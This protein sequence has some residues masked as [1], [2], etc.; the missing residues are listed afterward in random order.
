V[1]NT[2]KFGASAMA[3]AFALP[4]AAM[5]TAYDCGTPANAANPNV[6]NCVSDPNH[7]QNGITYNQSDF[8]PAA[9][10]K[11][12]LNGTVVDTPITNLVGVSV[13]GSTNNLAEIQ[14][15]SG[16]VVTAGLTGLQTTSS[17]TGASVIDNAGSIT[18]VLYGLNAVASTSGGT[19]TATVTNDAASGVIPAGSV[20]LNAPAGSSTAVAIAAAG[21][22]ASI[23]NSGT[24]T[25]NVS[26]SDTGSVYAL[27]ASSYAAGGTVSVTNNAAFSIT[28]AQASL[29]GLGT[30][31]ST[32]A[33]N[34]TNNAA[35]SL[36]T[37]SG[38]SA[39]GF[40]VAQSGS[41]AADTLTNN[42]ALTVNVAGSGNAYGID[43][44]QGAGAVALNNNAAI[45]AT[46]ASGTAAAIRVAGA[47][48]GAGVTVNNFGSLSAS[49][50]SAYGVDVEA[51]TSFTYGAPVN[52]ASGTITVTGTGSGGTIAGIKA[53]G[54][55]GGPVSITN[56]GSLLKVIATGSETAY[57]LNVSG[58]TTQTVN[59]SD[60]KLGSTV[61]AGDITVS[62]GGAATGIA[63]A[64][65]TGAVNLGLTGASLS[66][67]GGAGATGISISGNAGSVQVTTMVD[68]ANSKAAAITVQ[69][70]GS[71][72]ALGIAI[73]GTTGATTENVQLG[74][75]LSVTSTGGGA[76]GI[77]INGGTGQGVTLA[78]GLTVSAGGGNAYG[79]TL[80]KNTA[81]TGALSLTDTGTFQVSNSG[82]NGIATGI[83]ARGGTTQTLQLNNGLSVS[84]STSAT[85]FNGGNASG[86]VQLTSVSDYTV[87]GGTGDSFGVNLSGNSGDQTLTFDTAFKTT[88][89][90]GAATGI[91]VSNGNSLTVNANAGFTVTSS[92]DSVNNTVGLAATN[93]GSVQAKL[94]G[95]VDV[96]GGFAAGFDV[97]GTNGTASVEIDGPL[98][99]KGSQWAMGG[100][101]YSTS[102]TSNLSVVLGSDTN[103]TGGADGA[104]GVVLISPATLSFT[105][106]GAF[107]VSSTSSSIGLELADIGNRTVTFNGPVSVTGGDSRLGGGVY[108]IY[109]NAGIS[110]STATNLT[111]NSTF[112]VTNNG[113]SN[114]YGLWGQ[115]GVYTLAFND[116]LTV[117][118]NGGGAYG[119]YLSGLGYTG[120]GAGSTI[121]ITGPLSVTQ[122]GEVAGATATGIL[123]T[124]L[125][126][127]MTVSVSGALTASSMGAA[128]GIS[129][130]SSSGDLAITTGGAVNV[131]SYADAATG[132][133]ASASAGNVSI[134]ADKAVTVTANGGSALGV[135]G[136][137]SSGYAN[138]ITL[139]AGLTVTNSNGGATG[140]AATDGTQTITLT[141]PVSVTASGG[142]AYGINSSN[143]GGATTIHAPSSISATSTT[144]I[145][146]GI[147]IDPPASLTIDQGGTITAS[148]VGST[149][150]LYSTGVTGAQT[151]TLGNVTATSSEAD[152]T[153]ISLNGSGAITLTDTGTIA[154]NGVSNGSGVTLATTAAAANITATLGTVTTTGSTAPGVSLAQANG[155][156]TSGA[157]TATVGSVSTSGNGSTGV[158]LNGSDTGAVSLT[159][160][161]SVEGGHS[162][163]ISTTGS[164][165]DGVALTTVDGAGTVTNYGTISTA[166]T[167]GS[168]G[169]YAKSTGAGA[170][171][172]NSYKV[173]TSAAGSDAIYAQS[174]SGAVTIG[175][176]SVSTTKDGSRGI[177]ANSTSGNVAITSG[178]I[179]TSGTGSDGISAST[180]GTVNITTTGTTTTTGAGATG[181]YAFSNSGAITLTTAAISATGNGALGIRAISQ[182]GA[183]T[184]NATSTIANVP[185]I[186]ANSNTGNITLNLADGGTT[187]SQVGPAV[188]LYS[189]SGT[190][191]IN[192]GSLRTTALVSGDY[193][194]I[195]S[196]AGGGQ[197]LNLS[198]T[199]EA[200]SGEALWLGGGAAAINNAGTLNGYIDASE[201]GITT[202]TN[203]GTWN[204]YAADSAFAAGSTIANS[205]TVNIFPTGF[206]ATGV[207]SPALAGGQTMNI[208]GLASFANSGTLSLA[209]GQAGDVLNLGTASFIGSGHSTL[210]LDA[211]LAGV[212][213]GT[214]AAQTAD[215]LVV[216]ASSGVT[217][218]SIKDLGAGM[219]G[220]FN[221]N[222]IRV[223][224]NSSS[225]AGAYVLAGGSI[226][227]GFVQYQLLQD[228]NANWDLVGVPSAQA[229][230]LVR[231]VAE[232]QKFWRLSGDA[233]AQQM[234][235][236]QTREGWQGWVQAYGGTET[237]RSKPVYKE[238][239]LGQQV[240]FTPNLDIRND[241]AGV[242]LGFEWGH[243]GLGLGI[244]GGYG[245]QTGHVEATGDQIKIDGG[246]V[247]LYARYVSPEGLFAHMLGKVDRYTVKYALGSASA[248]SF[249]GTTYGVELEAGYH[250]RSGSLF[251]EPV[252]GI[253]W[254]HSDLD[255]FSG[256]SG[257]MSVA[258]S[259]TTS[260]YGHAGLRAGIETTSGNWK[261]RPYL[262]AGWEGEMGDAAHALLT[263]GGTGLGFDDLKDKGRARLEGGIEGTSAKGFGI[264]ARVQ[265][266]TGSRSQGIGG[267]AG[268]TFHF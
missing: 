136:A 243:A 220:Q 120:E 76:S 244:T 34:L 115:S 176:T 170:I 251:V 160:G 230:E 126:G 2:L 67:T 228:T 156:G 99:V 19:G 82:S 54:L 105:Q 250:L 138:A 62:S 59:F 211:N 218:I 95:A 192:L 167:G 26:A 77:T 32:G 11:V 106:S 45:S 232:A 51:G 194:G 163:G 173:T 241:A 104:L 256:G 21:G 148:G 64:N 97:E 213:V 164:G 35:I 248:P 258:F 1:K 221:F 14:A 57:G 139:D 181:L 71:S 3:M 215:R 111:V 183:I 159:I 229:F 135:S 268:V 87:S 178:T 4:G 214:S 70:N 198:G 52:A 238:T 88:A 25:F 212:A 158:V 125:G 200:N 117:S 141:G 175:S 264:F 240:A 129:L 78:K 69:D 199:V 23:T 103:I 132:L 42:A 29:V 131:T 93:V 245:T 171:T 83:Y 189:G 133:A 90:E 121:T 179:S 27:Q 80:G 13:T 187:S 10:L 12:I 153:G 101:V 5:A 16:S 205:G 246:N 201:A 157:I 50:N 149:Y 185:A 166:G 94:K 113:T 7:Y 24:L 210:V 79:V 84:A 209:N 236:K 263:S 227:K 154:A 43:V 144:G 151:V 17:G 92:S 20:T 31:N 261:L 142:D 36:T 242:Q 122:N 252:L 231:T 58:G 207:A 68:S 235:T 177:V 254:T 172:V 161:Q 6:V 150:G 9:G 191:T 204:A 73:A 96:E 152:A 108:G 72:G 182:S 169:I 174:V 89:T 123:S 119:I 224:T 49:G 118:G 137:S 15:L 56:Q 237:D 38:G 40:L 255:G 74:D 188:D 81:G 253:S 233:W 262:G 127:G 75:A 193:A 41:A 145:A 98:T 146:Y 197:V 223:V 48:S 147:Y 247:G 124:L 110:T 28:G 63:L 60:Y 155:D 184:I 143:S 140:I 225:T 66:V 216:G 8:S 39:T 203:T 180:G 102:S 195:Y 234:Q 208:T 186:L 91:S 46:S 165:A 196:Y 259:H 100:Y 86:A 162:G 37:T 61:Y 85:G 217:T 260:A 112:A 267:Q 249:G 219:A 55:S 30:A 44:E 266:V 128:T 22:S 226:N 107:N 114:V 53:V 202:F 190:V 130:S 265:G 239:V 222:G 206:V 257:G 168:D 134:T 18:G 116:G 109:D 65:A 47:S 33:V